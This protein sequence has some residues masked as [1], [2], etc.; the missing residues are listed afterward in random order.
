MKTQMKKRWR[1]RNHQDFR[2]WLHPCPPWIKFSKCSKRNKII[3]ISYWRIKSTRPRKS[4]TSKPVT[5]TQVS[6]RMQITQLSTV[7]LDTTTT[8]SKPTFQAVNR[9][10]KMNSF[11]IEPIQSSPLSVCHLQLPHPQSLICNFPKRKCSCNRMTTK[12]C[13]F[14]QSTQTRN[15]FRTI[16]RLVWSIVI[17]K[18]T[19]KWVYLLLSSIEWLNWKLPQWTK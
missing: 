3:I 9:T 8:L 14:G 4:T 16:V 13:P 18:R 15:S 5:T 2:T 10:R 17:I 6:S 11:A 12:L 7:Q 1:L 19:A